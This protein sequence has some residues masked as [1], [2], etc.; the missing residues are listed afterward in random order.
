MD[1]KDEKSEIKKRIR[2]LKAKRN[3]ALGRKA[4]QEVTNVRRG[5][6]SLKRRSRELARAAKAQAAAAPAPAA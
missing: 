5:I 2:A 4:S 3:D 1:V 6:R